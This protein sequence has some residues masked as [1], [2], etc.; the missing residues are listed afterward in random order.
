[1]KIYLRNKALY[2]A[3]KNTTHLL[4]PSQTI[5]TGMMTAPHTT[6][7]A[8]I[9]AKTSTYKANT[10][11]IICTNN[12][13]IAPTVTPNSMIRGFKQYS[14]SIISSSANIRNTKTKASQ[15]KV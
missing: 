2:L 5:A 11:K 4:T 8:H 6:V 7:T 9:A 13:S 1:M 3:D 12:T 15:A 10:A 14:F